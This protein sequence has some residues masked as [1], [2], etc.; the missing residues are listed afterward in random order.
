MTSRILFILFLPFFSNAQNL[1]PNGDLDEMNMCREYN[2]PCGP[3]GWFGVPIDSKY[4]SRSQAYDG[5]GGLQYLVY[6]FTDR[7]N[8]SFLETEILAPL[9]KDSS[10]IIEMLFNGDCID[11]GKLSVYMPEGD[12]LFESRQYTSFQPSVSFTSIDQLM[13]TNKKYWRKIRLQFKATGKERFFVI[14]NFSKGDV[15]SECATS[16]DQVVYGIDNISL[17]PAFFTEDASKISKQRLDELYNRTERHALL[18][19]YVTERPAARVLTKIDTLL[20]PDVL[21]KVDDARLPDKAR[22]LVDD[23]LK[24]IKLRNVDSIVVEGHTDNTGTVQHNRLL[25]LQRAESVRAYIL[26]KVPAVV[27]ARGL[28]S[29]KPV[30]DNR[31]ATGR[32]MNRRVAIYLYLNNRD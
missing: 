20:I 17:R 14:G 7:N 18:R 16:D 19:E 5:P 9:R 25:S 22:A 2:M 27:A 8:R 26:G 3:K 29:Q 24:G 30:A 12:F 6:D 21:F 28:D 31:T 13:K 15:F 23:F 32:Q 4:F 1:L 11:A 10:Y